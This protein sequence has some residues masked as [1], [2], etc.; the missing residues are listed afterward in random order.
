MS[1]YITHAD[2]TSFDKYYAEELSPWL[3]YREEER[4]AKEHVGNIPPMAMERFGDSVAVLS[5][6][7][8]EATGWPN[9]PSLKNIF[10]PIENENLQVFC[11]NWDSGKT[12]TESYPEP[13]FSLRVEVDE[14]QCVVFY[15]RDACIEAGAFDACFTNNLPEAAVSCARIGDVVVVVAG[16]TEDLDATISDTFKDYFMQPS[17]VVRYHYPID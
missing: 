2:K 9:A 6:A 4:A 8:Y 15:Q 13:Q 10:Q 12:D 14:G 16:Q 5:S 7:T 17:L 1:I 3:R 11:G